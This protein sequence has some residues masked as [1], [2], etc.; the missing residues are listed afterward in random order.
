MLPSSDATFDASQYAFFGKDVSEE[1]ELGGIENDETYDIQFAGNVGDE[2]HLFESQEQGSGSG[3]GSLSDVDDLTTTFSKLNRVVT[4]PKH[5]GIIGERSSGSFSRESSSAAEWTQEP[6]SSFEWLDKS[7]SDTEIFQQGKRWSS[8]PYNS[9]DYLSETRTLYRTS[10]SPLQQQQQQQQQPYYSSETTSASLEDSKPL[11]R[12]SSYPHK[13]QQ[14]PQFS[15][16]P[17]LVP[18]SSFTSFPPPGSKSQQPSPRNS[19]SYSGGH[20][21]PFSGINLSPLSSPNL[22][23]GLTHR[24]YGSSLPQLNPFSNR[25]QSNWTNQSLLNNVL[26]QQQQR[27]H[28]PVQ[29][30]L[31]HISAMQSHFFNS[32]APSP[33]FNKYGLTDGRDHNRHHKT[34]QKGKSSL[35]SQGS[36]SSSSQKNEKIT[37][38]FRS[39]H[40]TSEEI[41]SILKM[42]H[43][44]T[45]G[46]DPYTDDY[47]HQARIAKTS[48][49]SGLK[50]RFCPSGLKDSSNRTRNNSESH[51]YINV[52]A[53]GR[54][55]FSPVR[56][57]QQ[58]LLEFDSPSSDQKLSEKPLEQEPMFSARIAI[59]DGLY[60][61]LDVDDIDRLLQFSLPQD[62]GVQLRRR[63]Q[64]LLEG[65]ATALLQLVDP[66]GKSSNSLPKD[67]IVFM[68]LV[69]IPKGRK[70]ISKYLKLLHP[71]GDLSR[72]VC[73][74][75]FRHL[76]FLFG[77]ETNDELAKAVSGCVI[78]MDLNSLSACLAAVVCSSEQPPLRPIG[79]PYGDGASVILKCVLERATR[80]LKEHFHGSSS[81]SSMPN[82]ALWQAS[83]DAFFGLLTK[84]CISKYDSIVQSI[85]PQ[86]QQPSMEMTGSEV[87]RAIN[88]EM[89]VELLRASLQH[90]DDKQRKVLIDFAQKS[91]PVTGLNTRGGGGSRDGQVSAESVKG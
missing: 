84:Y 58:P 81:S 52:D 41:E 25:T 38:Q 53:H 68:R 29:P 17:I 65:L 60:I 89:P 2:Y 1:V 3:F 80:L 76:R 79:S 6:N 39:K 77:A 22:H 83:F 8:Q 34:S 69:S 15:S 50:H 27:M 4:G 56:K 21:Q 28:L 86:G 18:K 12:T 35:R 85:D 30:S 19:S 16:E 7:L 57:L 20:H 48:S 14:P 32:F 49:E 73:M 11:Y 40:M 67:D 9:P 90:T 91:T 82:P 72:I 31:S 51:S 64:V 88:K 54:I 71:A 45:H 66:L 42:Q 37:L 46:N 63:R 24:V 75:V 33:H 59:E 26:Q 78:G 36:D 47:Y 87:A 62:G 43:V 74:T 44:I 5:P 61:L 55:S 23:S 70:L 13:L 10:S